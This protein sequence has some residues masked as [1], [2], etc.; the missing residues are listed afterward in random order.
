M[1]FP[2]MERRV[3][4][5]KRMDITQTFI[6]ELNKNFPK[7]QFLKFIYCSFS[8]GLDFGELLGLQFLQL[9]NTF[10]HSTKHQPRIKLAPRLMKF[11]FTEQRAYFNKSDGTLVINGRLCESLNY[12]KVTRSESGSVL[13]FYPPQVPC[14]K[15]FKCPDS[16]CIIVYDK[17]N[18]L[19]ETNW[20]EGIEE[21]ELNAYEGF[22]SLLSLRK[23]RLPEERISTFKVPTSLL[24]ATI[25]DVV[26]YVETF[27]IRPQGEQQQQ[28]M[29]LKFFRF[30]DEGRRGKE[31]TIDLSTKPSY[32]D[33][34]VELY[35]M[36]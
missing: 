33:L 16:E 19:G 31:F 26:G 22:N 29:K 32:Y 27:E 30:D 3:K 7:L 18:P 35:D 12:F 21:L 24:R 28:I 34:K 25:H 36:D 9:T 23:E 13:G 15:T 10:I 17:T 4:I 2:D 14:L 11:I 20:A 8:G 1:I 5:F 6:D